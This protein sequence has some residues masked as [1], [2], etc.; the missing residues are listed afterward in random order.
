MSAVQVGN[1]HQDIVE[2]KQS[3]SK[4]SSVLGAANLTEAEKGVP[5]EDHLEEVTGYPRTSYERLRPFILIGLALL[6][7]GWWISSTV[8]PATRYRWFVSRVPSISD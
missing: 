3:A 1:E 6:I 4:S 2:R 8:L 5:R 7:L